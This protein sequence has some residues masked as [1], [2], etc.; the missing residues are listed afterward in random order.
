MRELY[1]LGYRFISSGAD[2][3][4]LIDYFKAH[5]KAF[6]QLQSTSSP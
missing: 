4:G 1:D 6:E 3:V 2:V 5:A